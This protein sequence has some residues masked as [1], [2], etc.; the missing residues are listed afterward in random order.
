MTSIIEYRDSS[1]NNIPPSLSP[2]GN[3]FPSKLWKL[4]SDKKY[5]SIQWGPGGKT[6]IVNSKIFKD[7]V[8]NDAF[9]MFKTQNF[10]S[11]VR[12]L[13]LYGF[14]KIP[15]ARTH[16]GLDY[17]NSS[18]SDLHQFQHQ[19]F[20]QNRPEYLCNVRRSTAASRRKAA[21]RQIHLQRNANHHNPM[22]CR[23]LKNTTSSCLQ[24]NRPPQHSG[25]LQ[26]F[27]E[28]GEMQ[29]YNKNNVNRPHYGRPSPMFNSGH[30][31]PSPSSNVHQSQ[32]YAP[33]STEQHRVRN[34]CNN[35]IQTGFNSKNLPQSIPS[36][37]LFY[38]PRAQQPSEL[39]HHRRSTPSSSVLRTVSS[40]PD[41]QIQQLLNTDS[42]YNGLALLAD[43]ASNSPD[44]R[45][46][47]GEP[48]A[49]GMRENAE[50]KTPVDDRRLFNNGKQGSED[51]YYVIK[52]SKHR[53]HLQSL[54]NTNNFNVNQGNNGQVLLQFP[55]SQQPQTINQSPST[56]YA[57]IT[58]FLSPM[59]YMNG[60]NS[61]TSFL[62]LSPDNQFLAQFG[63][64]PMQ[65]NNKI[66]Y[67]N[68][69]VASPPVSPAS[70]MYSDLT[71]IPISG[72]VP[73]LT[74]LS[75]GTEE[76]EAVKTLLLDQS[77]QP[78]NNMLVIPDE[79]IPIQTDVQIPAQVSEESITNLTIPG[80]SKEDRK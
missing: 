25:N 70:K 39:E 9:G 31:R 48:T 28:Y 49:R 41:H 12:Q 56:S 51:A 20:V 2:N 72:L 22:P 18:S 73:S 17:N 5:R 76:E 16:D 58:Q 33:Y 63:L 79:D 80:A 23:P 47:R 75:E 67:I 77:L 44:M 35:V 26:P 42:V 10:S 38:P 45:K 8:L 13:N 50:R 40:L 1:N 21:E 15:S 34:M 3:N 68:S 78:N 43:T 37:V 52:N 69:T 19:H 11:F 65:P 46:H 32:R 30:A 54:E 55:I 57:P 62:T 66:Q 24:G 53:N 4:C 59:N 64:S 74:K 14:R 29:M 60:S 6:I 27:R 36:S 7:E 71:S 61:G